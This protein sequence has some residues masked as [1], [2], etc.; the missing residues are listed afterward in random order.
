LYASR[1][2]SPAQKFSRLEDVITA[3]EEILELAKVASNYARNHMKVVHV[4]YRLLQ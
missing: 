3:F 2:G 1:R 4:G